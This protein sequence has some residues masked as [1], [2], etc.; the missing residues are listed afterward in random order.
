M[1]SVDETMNQT[2]PPAPVQHTSL[3]LLARL[4]AG[5]QQGWQRLVR[6]YGPLI[7]SWCRRAGLQ[8]EDASDAVQDVFSSISTNLEKFRRDQPGDSFRKWLKT[9]TMNRARDILRRDAGRAKATG[10]TTAQFQIA[11]QP[12]PDAT[13]V[14]DESDAERTQELDHLLRQATEMV[15]TDFEP[16]TWQAFWQTSVEGRE[17]ADVAADL[18]LSAN[19]VRIA[20]SRVRA[21]LREELDGLLD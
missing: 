12:A 14:V 15:R 16:A 21:R 8:Q 11:S 3:S 7:Y 20:K 18:G 5:D 9:V 1:G 19:A 4:R 17:T 10:G 6:L 13:D 2:S